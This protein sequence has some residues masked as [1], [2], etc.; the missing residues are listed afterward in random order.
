MEHLLS[1]NYRPCRN[2]GFS[3][4]LV[5]MNEYLLMQF[6]KIQN[7]YF[8]SMDFIYSNDGKYYF[9]ENNCNEQW[10]W[11]ENVPGV[12][13]SSSFIKVLLNNRVQ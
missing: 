3:F 12:D 5:L 4:C 7:F 13:M 9:V 1:N 11:L 8:S 2:A 6:M 10:I